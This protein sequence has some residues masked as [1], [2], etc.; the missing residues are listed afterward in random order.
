MTRRSCFL[1]IA[2]FWITMNGLLWHSEFGAGKEV[3]SA[4]PVSLVWQK[5][6]TA[7]D[8]S[9]M[10]I[11]HHGKKVGYCRWTPN[12]GQE[13]ATG[14]VATE[15]GPLEGRIQQPAGYTI[16]LEGSM[17]V[18]WL[19]NRL[20]CSLHLVFTTNQVWKELILRL[21]VRPILWEIRA[22]ADTEILQVKFAGEKVDWDRT[23][24]FAELR[25]PETLL[26]EFGLPLGGLLDMSG[27]VQSPKT[28][29]AGLTWEARNDTIRIGHSP[30]R[31]YRL[32][33]R[34]LD[35]S[36]VVVLVSRVG[37]ILRVELPDG[38]VFLN[39][40]LTGW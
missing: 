16:D 27:L 15:E 2:L 19:T 7:P 34:F 10:D 13:L 29:A 30:V 4:V 24:T 9:A 11:I 33:A 32:G 17:S 5:I 8:D 1:L 37:E 21:N 36:Q 35:R 31:G 20:G 18:P 6:L 22:E 12:V 26:S 39:D 40:V 3:G 25:N 38:L 23:F 14:K 28:L